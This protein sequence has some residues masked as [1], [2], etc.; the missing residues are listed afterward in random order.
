MNKL[1]CI[2]GIY[3]LAILVISTLAVFY[4]PSTTE[5]GFNPKA[6]SAL[7]SGG[8]CGALA[9]VWAYF[10]FRDQPW[11]TT[12]AIITTTIFLIAFAVRGLMAW[13]AYAAGDGTKWFAALLITL[14]FLA[15]AAHIAALIFLPRPT[16]RL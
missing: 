11:A 9:L 8:I 4:N 12:A 6:K 2:T 1:S 14:M 13:K 5:F 10:L 3:G 16:I 15:S 7:I